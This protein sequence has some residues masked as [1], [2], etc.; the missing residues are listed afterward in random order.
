MWEVWNS[1]PHS[2]LDCKY[3]T[4]FVPKYRKK[5]FSSPL[6]KP[7]AVSVHGSKVTVQEGQIAVKK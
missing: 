1:F 5:A 4:A 3:Q 7:L 6:V 2:R